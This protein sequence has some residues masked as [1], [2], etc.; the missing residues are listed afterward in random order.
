MRKDEEN[1][2]RRMW[3]IE[4]KRNE[5]KHVNQGEKYVTQLFAKNQTRGYPH[6]PQQS[7]KVKLW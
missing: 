5:R 4:K 3:N 6:V 1:W 7:W 2:Y